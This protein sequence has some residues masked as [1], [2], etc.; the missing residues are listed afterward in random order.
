MSSFKMLS[1]H[2]SFCSY[3]KIK[4]YSCYLVS[5]NQGFNP[6]FPCLCFHRTAL[7]GCSSPLFWAG[8]LKSRQEGGEILHTWS[9][10][11]QGPSI[12]IQGQ[13]R[14]G[15]A[16]HRDGQANQKHQLQEA[17]QNRCCH[18]NV[19]L[20][21]R[22]EQHSM[23]RITKPIRES[24]NKKNN[25]KPFMIPEY[26]LDETSSK[27]LTQCYQQWHH[28]RFVTKCFMIQEHTGSSMAPLLLETEYQ[29]ETPGVWKHDGT[30]VP[31]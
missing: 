15:V 13:V 29:C 17:F 20:E 24:K 7:M 4:G 6:C 9:A 22:N 14:V 12:N 18:G 10:A 8:R 2:A 21:P 26:E 30:V 1:I 11:Q 27:R 28:N 31:V 16:K 3:F 19:I 23:K 5:C 25:W